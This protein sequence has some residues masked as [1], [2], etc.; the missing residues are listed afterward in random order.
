MGRRKRKIIEFEN[1]T[2][3][4]IASEGKSLARVNDMVVFVKGAVPG[5]VVDLRVTKKRKSY[6]EA[7]PTQFHAYGDGREEPICQHFGLCG[8]CKWQQLNYQKQLFYKQKQVVDALTRIAKV[9]LPACSPIIASEKTEFYRNKLEF[10][11]TAKRWLTEEEIGG[12]A[13]LERR[14]VGFHIPGKFDKVLDLEA[15]YLQSELSNAIRDALREYGRTHHLE[16]F[17]L[18]EKEGFLRNVVIRTANTGEVMVILIVGQNNKSLISEVLTFLQEKFPEITSLQYIVNTKL[19]DSYADL[20]F[21]H[22][23]GKP[24][25]TETMEDLQFRVG[26]K[27]FYQTNSEQAYQLYKVARDFAKLTGAEVVYDLYTG[28]GTIAQF[29]AKKA[30]EV[31][32]IEYIDAAIED[33]KANAALNQLKN[34]RFYAG[35]MR[36]V[37]D[38]DFASKHPAPDVVI[39]DPPRA[40]MH[41]DVIK[42]LL[43]L[44][45]PRI[46][47]VS[48]N[49]ATQA[50]DIQLLAPKYQ[51]K[52]IQPV[53]MFPHTHH[54]ENVVLLEQN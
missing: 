4:D 18:M 2:I 40:G 30:K 48:C 45:A 25:I 21:H 38:D 41:E 23:A 51:V 43:K 14:G 3:E 15:C 8:G 47:Y 37:L 24:Y 1:V 54:V 22:F 32:G 53:D 17:N 33:A 13:D 52:A 34:T 28:I 27:S 29:V 9:P 36:K 39:T 6:L 42:M 11:F 16:F 19:N 7:I 12:D 50:R 5:D 26:P 31:I 49:P 46:V 44:N 20:N 10:T 35:D